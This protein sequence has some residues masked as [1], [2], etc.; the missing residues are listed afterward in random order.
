MRGAQKDQIIKQTSFER[1]KEIKNLNYNDQILVVNSVTLGQTA[2]DNNSFTQ[3]LL[4][5]EIDQRL[6]RTSFRCVI[7]CL[8]NGV[9]LLFSPFSVPK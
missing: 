3:G 8:V 2:K 6:H 4:R 1:K 5:Y 7:S 9:G